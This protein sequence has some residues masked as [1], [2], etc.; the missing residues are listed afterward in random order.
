M[1]ALYQSLHD[2]KIRQLITTFNS[3]HNRYAPATQP[4]HPSPP[5]AP[6][7]P[8]SSVKPDTQPAIELLKYCDIAEKL[9][10]SSTMVTPNWEQMKIHPV[11]LAKRQTKKKRKKL[12]AKI[13]KFGSA[14]GL[15][16]PPERRAVL[17][18]KADKGI[19]ANQIYNMYN[20][21]SPLN[22]FL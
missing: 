14:K 16:L 13:T 15:M 8:N 17:M 1:Q 5:Q 18:K 3:T 10:A 11:L 19:R 12:K 20:N 7:L 4:N 6:T 22:Y 2:S 9:G 21:F